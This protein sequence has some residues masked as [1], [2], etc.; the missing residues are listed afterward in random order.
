[1]KTLLAPLGFLILLL[2]AGCASNIPVEI[3]EPLAGSPTI[4]AVQSNP[5]AFQGQHVRWGGAIVSV[6]NAADT[7]E[8]EVVAR[9]L[10]ASGRPQ[11]GDVT[12][13]RFLIRVT[14]FHDPAI[15]QSGRDL[16]VYGRIDGAESRDIGEYPYTYPVVNAIHLYG[17]PDYSQYPSAN[18]YP[19]FQF[20]VGV[21]IG[22]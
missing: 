3:R 17:W 10:G 4:A 5:K 18:P 1:M 14:G 20:G 19:A 21:G 12:L 8:I 9:V 13:G 7:A 16:T 22:L 15:Y 2:E 6:K 11:H